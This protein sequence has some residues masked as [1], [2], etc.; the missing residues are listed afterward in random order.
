[1]VIHR[2]RIYNGKE[3]VA[4]GT[5]KQKCPNFQLSDIIWETDIRLHSVYCLW[6]CPS[7]GEL[8]G[9]IAP[10]LGHRPKEPNGEVSCHYEKPKCTDFRAYQGVLRCKMLILIYKDMAPYKN[11]ALKYAYKRSR[12]S[13]SGTSKPSVRDLVLVVEKNKA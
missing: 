5:K 12:L 10:T 11:T 4:S 3:W 8:S 6:I 13:L 7:A 1:M 2:Y 9:A